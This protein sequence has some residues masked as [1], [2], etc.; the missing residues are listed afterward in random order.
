MSS[1]AG[2]ARELIESLHA[3]RQA[4]HG[5]DH[6]ERLAAG[7][8]RLCR[9]QAV[10]LVQRDDTEIL[11]LARSGQSDDPLRAEWRTELEALWQRADRQGY[12][13]CPARSS[14]GAA[15]WWA[16]VRLEQQ[17]GGWMLINVPDQERAQLNELLL[18][19][20]LVA[21]LPPPS[22]APVDVPGSAPATST[23]LVTRT[24]DGAGGSD[25]DAPQ[26]PAAA[27]GAVDSGPDLADLWARLAEVSAQVTQQEQFGPAA[28]ALVNALAARCP[29]QQVLLGWRAGPGARPQVVAIS[30][31]DKF[32][33]GSAPLVRAEDALDEALDF[34]DGV[35][36]PAPPAGA[37]TDTPLQAGT[38]TLH[39]M[40]AHALLRD[41]LGL[42]GPVHLLSIPLRRGDTPVRA[43]VL[44]AFSGEPPSTALRQLLRSQLPQLLPWLELLHGRERAWPLRLRDGAV[45]QLQ[46]WFGPGRP[47]PKAGAVVLTGLLLYAVF[48][49]WDYRVHASALLATDSTRIVSAQYDG[50]V[51][52]ARFGAGDPVR[53]GE[54]LARLDTRELGQQDSDAQAELKRYQAEADKARAGGALAELEVASARAAQAQARLDRVRDLLAQAEVRAPFDGVV[55]E[56]ERKDL[57]GAPVRKGDKLYRLARVEGLYATLQVPER[58]AAEVR[59]GAS[60]ELMLVTRPDQAIPLRV[61]AVVPVAQ[62]KGTEGNHFLVRA[63]LLQTPEAWW[64]PGMSGSARIDAGERRVLWVLTHRLVDTVRLALWW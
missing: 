17:R 54:L 16:A 15:T 46:G 23:A 28:L 32:D 55:V 18:R 41:E 7:L 61:L 40:P 4:P 48:G 53:E 45:T 3:L 12:A 13:T 56:G 34:D 14:Q 31:R 8:L 6:W 27:L 38:Q 47:L 58:D 35:W 57:Q 52:D 62:T 42:P 60:G 44:L 29:A 9:A 63:E 64:R 5:A 11:T 20:Q 59:P 43:V 51:D 39:D 19:A 25:D 36:M 33:R 37:G 1:G 24:V 30:H 21:D 2:P 10:W 22:Q 50:R 49:H 26:K